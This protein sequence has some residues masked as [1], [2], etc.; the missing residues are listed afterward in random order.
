MESRPDVGLHLRSRRARTSFAVLLKGKSFQQLFASQ[1]ISGFGDWI[2]MIAILALVKRITENEFAVA[3]ALLARLVPALFFGPVS[4][5]IADRW[6]RKKLMVVCDLASPQAWR[7]PPCSGSRR[8][9]PACP[10]WSPA[11]SSRAPTP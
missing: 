8:R 6:D 4:G 3:A 7:P 1:A 9:M 2:G 11:T 10:T 5:V